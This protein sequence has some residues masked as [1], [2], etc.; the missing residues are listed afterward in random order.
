MEINLD[1]ASLKLLSV[2]FE[3]TSLKSYEY[4]Y[5]LG[6]NINLNA[7]VVSYDETYLTLADE[8]SFKTD[9]VIWKAGVKGN[10]INGLTE[11][12]FVGNRIVINEFNQVLN[13]RSIFAIRDVASYI[14]KENPKGFPMLATVEQQYGKQLPNNS[15]NLI[16]EKALQSFAYK[17]KGTM[18]TT[19]RRK[20]VVNLTNW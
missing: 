13:T 12:T 4:L 10:P 3:N 1:E 9:T 18:A 5:E 11:E 8:T 7:K 19:D 16:K 6:I 17:D 2:M 14:S 20:P 15:I